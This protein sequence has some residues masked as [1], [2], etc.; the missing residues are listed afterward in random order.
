MNWIFGDNINTDLIT[1]GRYNITT[2]PKKLA[3]TAFIEYLP[4][5]SKKVKKGDFIVAGENFGCGSSRE[6]AA[7]ALKY[8]GIQA[9]LAK[10][11]ARIF[12]RNCLN[13]GLL[14]ITMEKHSIRANDEL[15]LDVKNQLLVNK[16]QKIKQRI[17]IPGLMLRLHKEG[18]IIPYLQ[19]YGLDSLSK[20]G[21]FK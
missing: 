9:I 17:V 4:F 13:I 5:F 14:A 20:L 12:Y 19:K 15:F 11:F 1:P 16:T 3:Q 2:D 21:K 6:T 18:G 7:L 8:S 10:S